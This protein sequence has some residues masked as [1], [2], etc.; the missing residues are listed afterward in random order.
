[1][2]KHGSLEREIFNLMQIKSL[3]CTG[4]GTYWKVCF[5]PF[6]FTS[7]LKMVVDLALGREKAMEKNEQ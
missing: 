2:N 6:V 4:G 3:I 5:I 7:D 1:M